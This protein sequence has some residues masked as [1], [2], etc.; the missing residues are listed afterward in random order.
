MK[1]ASFGD[2]EDRVT[3]M[4][5][6]ATDLILCNRIDDAYETVAVILNYIISE[7]GFVLLSNDDFKDKLVS[8]IINNKNIMCNYMKLVNE[9]TYKFICCELRK[10][11]MYHYY[12]KH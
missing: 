8:A 9:S 2:A 12:N 7:E 4:S 3:I 1:M 5:N 6:K 10:Y 11:N